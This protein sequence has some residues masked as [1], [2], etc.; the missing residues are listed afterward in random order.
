MKKKT[1]GDVRSLLLLFLQF[2]HDYEWKYT[3][4]NAAATR[5]IQSPPFLEPLRCAGQN[6]VDVVSTRTAWLADINPPD[7][8]PSVRSP[9]QWQGRTKPQDITPNTMYDVVFCYRNGGSG[10]EISGLADVNPPDITSLQGVLNQRVMSGG[11]RPP[12]LKFSFQ[13]GDVWFCGFYPALPLNGV[14]WSRGLCPGGLCPVAGRNKTWRY[15]SIVC[16]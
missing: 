7:I 1:S 2:C 15:R 16:F 9:C 6:P 13:V 5:L 11:L 8:T 3:E 14:L 10:S 4:L 12:I